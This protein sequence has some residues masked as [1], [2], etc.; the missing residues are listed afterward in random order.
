LCRQRDLTRRIVGNRLA[1]R[2]LGG[3]YR[4]GGAKFSGRR[5]DDLTRT[6]LGRTLVERLN[7]FAPTSPIHGFCETGG[8]GKTATTQVLAGSRHSTRENV[9]PRLGNASATLA[10]VC[11][12]RG[13]GFNQN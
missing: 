9:I 10:F 13:Y 6:F 1:R 3:S 2:I 12:F 8:T 5:N 7:L 11:V 4:I